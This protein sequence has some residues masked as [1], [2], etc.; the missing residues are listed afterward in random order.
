MTWRDDLERLY[1]EDGDRL[2]RA[3]FLYS[4]DREVASEAVAEA[5]AQALRRGEEIASPAGWVWT[6]A[7]RLAAG[8]L[9]RRSV[10]RGRHAPS[11]ESGEEIA[12]TAAAD[13]PGMDTVDTSMDIMRALAR[14]SVKQRASVVL[15]YYGGYRLAE[16]ARMI[17]STPAAVAVHLNRARAKLRDLIGGGR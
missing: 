10:E 3:I 11:A 13:Q 7:F 16:V 15:Y 9:R 4:R 8:E 6:A 17:G 5:F 12:S 2:W 14:L 1:R